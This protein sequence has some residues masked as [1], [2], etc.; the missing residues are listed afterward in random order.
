MT[1]GP[2]P[3]R[4]IHIHTVVAMESHHLDLPSKNLLPSLL[5]VTRRAVISLL[6]WPPAARKPIA[7]DDSLSEAGPI[8]RLSEVRY[9]V[10]GSSA[11][12]GDTWEENAFSAIPYRLAKDLSSLHHNLIVFL[13]PVLLHPPSFHKHWTLITPIS[14]CF[15]VT[16]PAIHHNT[17]PQDKIQAFRLL[18]LM[19]TQP[20]LHSPAFVLTR[21]KCEQKALTRSFSTSV[22]PPIDT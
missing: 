10:W 13:W 15:S 11:L 14:T 3:P 6:L 20:H 5:L 1:K 22:L 18:L 8:R 7:Q 17:W 9:K 16:Q 12:M 19:W 4:Q 2:W 21:L